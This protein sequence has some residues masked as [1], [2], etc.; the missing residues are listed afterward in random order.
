MNLSVAKQ[1]R[2]ENLTSQI[3]TTVET[4]VN[5]KGKFVNPRKFINADIL[6]DT[7][8]LA[9]NNSYIGKKQYNLSNYQT[10][11]HI[12]PNSNLTTIDR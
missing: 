8:T 6:D 3:F 9:R 7:K 11:E 4:Q 2:M 1:K 12:F 10:K 5:K